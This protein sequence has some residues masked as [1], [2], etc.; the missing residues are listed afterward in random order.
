M[1]KKIFPFFLLLLLIMLKTSAQITHYNPTALSPSAAQNFIVTD[2]EGKTYSYTEWRKLVI[3]GDYNI[4]RTNQG[5]SRPE[6]LLYRYTAEEKA[7]H[8]KN[9]RRP[10]ESKFFVTGELIK[11]FKV[12]DIYG[13]TLNAKAWAGK[14][15]VLNFWFVGCQPCQIEI[16]E[17]NKIAA[18]YSDNPNVIFIA[19]ALDASFIISNSI[20]RNPFGYVLIPDGKR[21]ADLFKI[22][23]YPTNVVIDKDG[24]VR[25]HSS[26]LYTNN[27]YWIDKTIEEIELGIKEL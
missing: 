10:A 27:A 19:I 16:P 18:K 3:S 1:S 4:R 26:G 15:V 22:N 23:L 24:K 6:F 21:Y 20:K 13:N 8:L 2:S 25:F 5:D 7:E 12:S 11:P 9:M 17:L 14:T